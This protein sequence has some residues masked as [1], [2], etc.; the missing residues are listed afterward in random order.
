MVTVSDRADMTAAPKRPRTAYIYSDET[1][2][3]SHGQWLIIVAI[4]ATE[5]RRLIERQLEVIEEISKKQFADWHRCHPRRLG[6][7]L[8]QALKVPE[9]VG[10]IYYRVYERISPA[11]YHGYTIETVVD[12]AKMVRPSLSAIFV[13]EGF[14]RFQRCRLETEARRRVG[15]SEVWAGGFRGSS[16]VRLTDA[17]AGLIAHDRFSPGSRKHF[18]EL[19]ADWFVELKDETPARTVV[20][21]GQPS[22]CPAASSAFE[23]SP[24]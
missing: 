14:T 5:R 6:H 7:Y 19:V 3:H 24:D 16:I 17:L 13:P 12:I 9:L 21:R 20:R 18:P 2:Q 10:G 22:H 1:G 15:R 11:D 8:E 23:Q 4:V